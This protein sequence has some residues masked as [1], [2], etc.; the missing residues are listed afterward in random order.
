MDTRSINEEYSK[1]GMNL[2]KTEDA[3]VDIANSQATIIFLSSQHAKKGRDKVIHA[4]CEK[5]AEKYKWGIPCD[6]TITV[7]EPNCEGMTEEQ[8]RI[9]L[10]HEL[11]HVGIE[12]CQDG[13]E[14]YYIKP[15][16]LEDFKL[17]IDRFGTDWSKTNED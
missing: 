14:N 13:S 3:L 1:I 8:I 2:I 15:H 12:F 16:D 10:F 4:Q 9:L 6:F 7:F 17:I 11:L 5:V